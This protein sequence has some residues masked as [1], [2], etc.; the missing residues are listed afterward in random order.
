MAY[1]LAVVIAFVDAARFKYSAMV[2][3]RVVCRFV[4]AVSVCRMVRKKLGWS[5]AAL[6]VLTPVWQS[7][8]SR[9]WIFSCRI[10]PPALF[11]GLGGI[12]AARN[13]TFLKNVLSV[14][15][16]LILLASGF[17]LAFGHWADIFDAS[18]PL[19]FMAAVSSILGWYGAAMRLDCRLLQF[20]GRHSLI[21]L[22]CHVPVCKSSK[23]FCSVIRTKGRTLRI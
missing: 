4:V 10:F 22:G 15:M 18:S 16:T 20:A 19:F 13:K 2:F 7:F 3:P 5:M 11:F 17:G 14:P 21:L 6:F 12:Y 23:C 9:E 8:I 1:V